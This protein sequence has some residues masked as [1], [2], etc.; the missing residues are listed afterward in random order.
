MQ[1][2][3]EDCH[4]E[5]YRKQ[6]SEMIVSGDPEPAVLGTDAFHAQIQERRCRMQGY[7]AKTVRDFSCR[8]DKVEKDMTG[9]VY[10]KEIYRRCARSLGIMKQSTKRI[11]W[12][13][14]NE[15][16]PSLL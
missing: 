6:S 7:D 11:E 8:S 3:H 16:A 10:A 1:D 14:R 4:N 15:R 5:L 2:G 13:K 9:S 12:W